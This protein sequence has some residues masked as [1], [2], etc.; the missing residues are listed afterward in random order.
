MIKVWIYDDYENQTCFFEDE[1]INSWFG[2]RETLPCLEVTPEIA[3]RLRTARDDAVWF[4]DWIY[5]A[6][7]SLK[8]KPKFP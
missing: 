3:A 1:E 2:T 5:I 8:K 4:E 6:K 7:K